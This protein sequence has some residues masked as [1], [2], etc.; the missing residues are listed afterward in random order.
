M[1]AK[2]QK[3]MFHCSSSRESLMGVEQWTLRMEATEFKT[4][5][6]IGCM[7]LPS[8]TRLL[9]VRCFTRKMHYSLSSTT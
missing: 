6:L 5:A 2:D 7:D 1:D 8:Q 4:S 3:K 9:D